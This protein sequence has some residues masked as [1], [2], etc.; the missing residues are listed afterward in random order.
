MIRGK[1]VTL[2]GLELIDAP[3]IVRRYN[4]LEVRRFLLSVVPISLEEERDRIKRS[5]ELRRK[6]EY[7]MFGIELNKPKRLIGTC[8]LERVSHI[9]R[10]AEVSIAIF[11]KTY[12]D[13]GL[14][15]EATQLLL[16]FAFNL[17]NLHSIWLAVFEDN[18]RAQ[19][20][21]GKVGFQRVGTRRQAIFRDGRYIDMYLYDIL[22]E[23]YRHQLERGTA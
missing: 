17:L 6:G 3:E 21:Y 14:G 2:R 12:W 5:W 15:T 13:Q 4:D 1:Y 9:H 22:A 7:Y 8:G 10:R 20:I 23:E 16:H 11:N 18:R 19:H